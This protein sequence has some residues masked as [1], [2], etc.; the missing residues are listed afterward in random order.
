MEKHTHVIV[1]IELLHRVLCLICG[2]GGDCTWWV[3][4]C[5]QLSG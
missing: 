3:Y 5:L 4:A 1:L 2:C